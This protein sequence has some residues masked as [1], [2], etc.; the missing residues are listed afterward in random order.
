MA[1]QLRRSGTSLAKHR[2]ITQTVSSI[3]AAHRYLFC[4]HLAEINSKS[5]PMNRA[6]FPAES[7][8]EKERETVHERGKENPLPGC[9]MR[10]G[11]Y[12]VRER[13]RKRCGAG[14]NAE[15]VA[16]R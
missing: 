2:R 1:V 8:A 14:A 9:G 13:M 10:R 4:Y 3:G 16:A 6:P 7:L 5:Y 12:A 15:P 11:S